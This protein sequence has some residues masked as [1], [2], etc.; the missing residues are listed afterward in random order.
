ML[1]LSA[2]SRNANTCNLVI[3]VD[4]L[5]YAFLYDDTIFS[6]SLETGF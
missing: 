2:H 6:N 4:G 1:F 5:F 3:Q